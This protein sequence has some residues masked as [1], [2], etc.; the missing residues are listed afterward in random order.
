MLVKCGFAVKQASCLKIWQKVML[1][2]MFL[3]TQLKVFVQRI[4]KQGWLQ[5]NHSGCLEFSFLDT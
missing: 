3:A 4:A 1:E 5:K 2:L